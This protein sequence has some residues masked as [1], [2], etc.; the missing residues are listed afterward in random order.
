[1]KKRVLHVINSLTIGGA[2]M[3]LVNSLSPGGLNEHVENYL[4]YFIKG[5]D[6][7]SRLV[8]KDVKQICL[9]YKGGS[10]V[11]RLL[12]ELRGIIRENKI[13]V[14]HTHLTPSNIYVNLIRP[15]NIPQLHTLHIA[16]TTDLETRHSLKWLERR[17]FFNKKYCNL[18]FL[19]EFNK[20]DFLG[21]IKFEG[22]SFVV[23]NFVQDDFFEHNPKLFTGDKNRTLRLIAIGN[24]RLQ[25]N[26][27]YLLEIFKYLK[28]H[29]VSLD[30][31]GGGE[32]EKYKQVIDENQLNV[33]LKG[34]VTNVNDVIADYDLFIMSSTNE[35]FPLSVFEAMAAGVPVMLTNIPPLREIVKDN[36]LYFELDDA[37]KAAQQ[38]I[39][40]QQNK[41]DISE[42]AIKAKGYAEITV[43][44]NI[45]IKK[46]LNIYDQLTP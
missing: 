9:D 39:A 1:M 24:F 5:G 32:L 29:Y 11:V 19:S 22:Q 26:Y 21:N 41:T 36:A 27:F 31:Y 30:I 28:G 44:R 17:L 35:G 18:I 25:K 7:L 16:Y 6:Y 15:K 23:P 46:L 20:Q 2:E 43:R 45:Y 34:Q 37:P 8:D 38:I 33:T 3:L 4:V 40:I 14:I 42:M 12:R 10:D 13:D